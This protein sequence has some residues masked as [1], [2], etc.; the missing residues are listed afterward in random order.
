MIFAA[1]AQQPVESGAGGVAG[2]KNSPVHVWK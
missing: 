2:R 1:A